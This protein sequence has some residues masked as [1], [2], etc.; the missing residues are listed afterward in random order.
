MS[1][2]RRPSKKAREIAEN[3]NPLLKSKKIPGPKARDRNQELM[4]KNFQIGSDKPE[5]QE[6]IY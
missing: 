6:W 5:V 2:P 4:M 3:L 1:M